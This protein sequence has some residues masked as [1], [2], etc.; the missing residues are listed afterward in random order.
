M[1]FIGSG[2]NLFIVLESIKD[3]LIIKMPI[4]PI[5]KKFPNTFVLYEKNNNKL[6]SASYE[7]VKFY[8]VN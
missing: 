4:S 3:L 6:Y 5:S 1:L 2:G 7:F 8:E